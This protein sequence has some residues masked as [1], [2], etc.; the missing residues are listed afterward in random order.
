MLYVAVEGS[1]G[2]GEDGPKVQR[3]VPSCQP[4][5]K[6]EFQ[7]YCGRKSGRGKEIMSATVKQRKPDLGNVTSGE[8]REGSPHPRR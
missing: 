1:H 5:R 7:S 6:Q 8:N 2:K 3:V 4:E